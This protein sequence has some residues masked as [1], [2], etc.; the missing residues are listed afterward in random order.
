MSNPSANQVFLNQIPLELRTWSQSNSTPFPLIPEIGITGS[1]TVILRINIVKTLDTQ[2][3][4]INSL[5]LSAPVPRF[6]FNLQNSKWHGSL[7]TLSPSL[8][9]MYALTSLLP[10][11]RLVSVPCILVYAQ[12]PVL[13]SCN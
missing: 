6:L 5:I 2:L 9:R 7:H 4:R 1:P 11:L 12:N 3:R 10:L 8:A 13:E